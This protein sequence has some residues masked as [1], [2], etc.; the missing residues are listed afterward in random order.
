VKGR[1]G[2]GAGCQLRRGGARGPAER[3]WAERKEG[4]GESWARFQGGFPPFFFFSFL[5]SFPKHSPNRILKAQFISNQK[6]PTQNKICL[7]MNAQNH[8]TKLMINFNFHKNYLFATLNA[9]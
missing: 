5:V 2:S 6:Q 4:G 3:D 1:E 7:S 9:H 8:I